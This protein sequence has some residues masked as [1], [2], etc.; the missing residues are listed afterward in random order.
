MKLAR[1]VFDC[2]SIHE[3]AYLEVEE[4]RIRYP[5]EWLITKDSCQW[6][7]IYNSKQIFRFKLSSSLKGAMT[8][9]CENM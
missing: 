9:A 4:P 8:L 2:K 5:F 3:G 6:L 1:D 7:M